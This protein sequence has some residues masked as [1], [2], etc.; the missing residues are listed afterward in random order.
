MVKKMKMFVK[1]AEE[2]GSSPKTVSAARAV[3]ETMNA[4]TNECKSQK[5]AATMK[6]TLA[7]LQTISDQ[8]SQQDLET[9]WTCIEGVMNNIKSFFGQGIQDIRK[10]SQNDPMRGIE[11]VS[12]KLQGIHQEYIASQIKWQCGF[13]LL[14]ALQTLW[15]CWTT[16]SI[17]HQFSIAREGY[18][19]TLQQVA[20]T[21]TDVEERATKLI[22]DFHQGLPVKPSAVQVL[23]VHLQRGI[24]ELDKAKS[25]LQENKSN[26][27]A[28]RSEH[29]VGS[30]TSAVSAYRS[31]SEYVLA[32]SVGVNPFYKALAVVSATLAGA[33]AL[34]HGTM[35][36]KCQ[37]AI[38]EADALLADIKTYEIKLAE[39][40]KNI[41]EFL[42]V[43]HKKVN[44]KS[45]TKPTEEQQISVVYA[46]TMLWLV[47]VVGVV[48]LAVLWQHFA[49]R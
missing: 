46:N 9:S 10:E 15:E 27:T 19:R 4:I 24:M 32:A 25:L 39:T 2:T 48:I 5:F 20:D 11:A 30:V 35:A 33:S 47:T 40:V 6:D 7:E 23:L 29:I 22:D 1:V 44:S 14:I 38:V 28:R 18:T 34:V 21:L 45:P 31:I 41:E 42:R 49:G 3:L 36:Y 26:V 16:F 12:M 37:K 13:S 8:L 17:L 43:L